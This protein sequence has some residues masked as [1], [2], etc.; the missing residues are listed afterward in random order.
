MRLFAHPLHQALIVFALGG[1]GVASV[2]AWLGGELADRL[3]VGVS[4]HAQLD[5][6]RS[7]MFPAEPPRDVAPSSAR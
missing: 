7:L 1:A 6:R 4:T 3:G 2:T 5:A